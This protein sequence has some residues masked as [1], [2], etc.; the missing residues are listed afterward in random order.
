[1]ELAAAATSRSPSCL[2]HA[3]ANPAHERAIGERI[4][5][6]SQA[7]CCGLA[8]LGR[9]AP[10]FREYERT[11]TTVA[12]AYIK[13]I[14]RPLR[15]ARWPAALRE[16]GIRR[17]L[18]IMQSNGGLVSPELALRLCRSAS[19]NRARPPASCCAA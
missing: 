19:S 2:L 3:Y 1:M 16:L 6:R 9:L 11:S 18:F 13:P 5:A 14:V 4:A 8:L 12:N 10:K 17:E 15:D 7:A